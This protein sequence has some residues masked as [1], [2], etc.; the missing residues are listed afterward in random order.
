MR[1]DCTAVIRGCR[2]LSSSI[3]LGDCTVIRGCRAPRLPPAVGSDPLRRL[4]IGTD[5]LRISTQVTMA[6]C[7]MACMLPCIKPCIGC[8]CMDCPMNCCMDC[9]MAMPCCTSSHAGG[10]A[11]P[12]MA[13]M[14]QP[15]MREIMNRLMKVTPDHDNDPTYKEVQD[16][17]VPSSVGKPF[18]DAPG[19]FDEKMEPRTTEIAMG[20]MGVRVMK[21]A[22]TQMVASAAPH[23]K[24][25][26]WEKVRAAAGGGT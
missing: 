26:T 19:T 18:K 10:M 25:I 14:M 15:M 24:G 4:R 8:A 23:N 5:S 2:G 6:D 3:F 11:S 9:C 13:K 17:M 21:M 1:G 12:L 20:M 16:F 22:R 7:P